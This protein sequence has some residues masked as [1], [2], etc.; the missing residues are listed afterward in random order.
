M[1]GFEFIHA[2]KANFTFTRT[3]R[4][5]GV[6]RCRTKSD[7]CFQTPFGFDEDSLQTL[8]DSRTARHKEP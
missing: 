5:L 6:W 2:E 3:S 4:V 7:S 8:K 1:S